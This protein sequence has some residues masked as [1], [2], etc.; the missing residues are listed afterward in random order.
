MSRRV[1]CG[2]SSGCQFIPQEVH[3]I[4]SAPST[5]NA[6]ARNI[7]PRPAP[8]AASPN[9]RPANPSERSRKAIRSERRK[10]PNSVPNPFHILQKDLLL[11][12]VIEFRG[13]AVG[14]AGDALGRFKVPSF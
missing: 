13:P 2:D 6:L 9:S 7:A 1:I 8:L 3:A 12:A 5:I 14:V 11:A 10:G 4:T